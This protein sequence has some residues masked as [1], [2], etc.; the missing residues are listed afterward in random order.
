MKLNKYIIPILLTVTIAGSCTKKQDVGLTSTVNMAGEWWVKYYYNNTELTDYNKMIS[1][2]TSDP[3]SG[4]VWVDDG[5]VW[6]FKAKFD[7]DYANLTFKSMASTPNTLVTN[8]TIRV[9]EGK[10]LLGA[11]R[12]LSGNTVD[13]I[14][15]K[16]EFSDD[17]GNEYEIRGHYDTGFFVDHP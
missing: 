10:I 2:N 11:G 14:Y 7:V 5:H 1:F 8:G 6:P 4:K 9:V 17:P 15:L 12:S 3:N 16:L 13:S